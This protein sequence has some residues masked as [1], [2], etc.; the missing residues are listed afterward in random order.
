VRAEQTH[1]ITSAALGEQRRIWVS[2]PDNYDAARRSYP[3]VL[4]LDGH[5]RR[6]RDLAV[7]SVRFD[8]RLDFFDPE[9]PAQIVVGIASGNRGSDFGGASGRMRTF[10]LD[11]VG[12][13]LRTRYRVSGLT[14]VVGHSLSA[15]FAMGL[16]CQAP[17][18]LHA[19]VA[20]SPALADTVD[21]RTAQQCLR[22]WTEG[23]PRETR[24][25]FIA[26]GR[27][28]NDRTEEAF[29][30]QVIALQ[31]WLRRPT[32]AP[33][34]WVAVEYPA[35]SHSRTPLR[36]IPDGI[37]FT[38]SHSIWEP[39]D[40]VK[41]SVLAGRTDPLG[42]I[43]EHMRQLSTRIGAPVSVSPGWLKAAI[44]LGSA[45]EG[46]GSA[47]AAIDRGLALYPEDPEF[48]MF[49]AAADAQ[50]GDTAA[51]L[52][53]LTT[54]RALLPSLSDMD[55]DRRAELERSIAQR[56]ATLRRRPEDG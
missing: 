16:G 46:R 48:L 23:R 17:P 45:G 10:V 35:M 30:R 18:G 2:L 36:G 41:R 37:A 53:R 38:F 52:G 12:E 1:V 7:A 28:A 5:D 27:R 32:G 8:A 40:S 42:A 15:T 9:M 11:E 14:T 3:V 54:A 34:R 43:D 49:A 55:P 13:L 22:R 4:V 33:L 50:A 29:R 20:I 25:L 56:E 26:Y 44:L 47:R 24:T 51:A 31:D 19:I 39:V 21:L 6:L